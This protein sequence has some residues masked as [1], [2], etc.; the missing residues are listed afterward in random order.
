M[1]TSDSPTVYQLLIELNADDQYKNKTL[2]QV[3]DKYSENGSILNRASPSID[4]LTRFE[5]KPPQ[6][7]KSDNDTTSLV[8][9]G[10]CSSSYSDS[11]GQGEESFHSVSG[12]MTLFSPPP[13]EST[14]SS[15]R[16]S[17]RAQPEH[18]L[19]GNLSGRAL[20]CNIT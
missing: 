3:I 19:S 2:E 1:M 5:D 6:L 10:P 9:A 4:Y 17:V 11:N 14:S 20:R 7:D 13:K 15:D 8:G 18:I 12:S 16:L